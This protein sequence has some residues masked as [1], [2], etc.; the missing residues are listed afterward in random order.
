[1]ED[2]AA[3]PPRTGR[4]LPV[5]LTAHP[6][7]SWVVPLVRQGQR[8]T[9]YQVVASSADGTVWDSGRI[10]SG[11]NAHVRWGGPPVAPHSALRWTVRV[12]DEHARLSP[13]AHA[14]DLIAGPLTADDWTARWIEIPA[15]H[16]AGE[17]FSWDPA[18]RAWRARLH[19]AG[20]GLLR[21]LVDG[22]AVNPDASDPSRTA[23]SRAASRSYDV[24]GLLRDGN[25]H[26]L[27]VVAGIGHYG[28]VLTEPRAL[29][30]LRV[31]LDNGSVVRVGTGPHWRHGPS[32]IIREDPFYLEEHDARRTFT[33]TAGTGVSGEPARA[34]ERPVATLAP[35]AGPPLAVVEEI[36]AIPCGDAGGVLV[37]DAG[38][39]VAGRSRVVVRGAAP[40]TRIEIVHGEKL[41]DAGRVGTLNIRLPDDRDR[42][43]Q[44]LVWTCAGG[45]DVAEAWFAFY[46]FRYVEV[47]GVPAGAAV[48]VTARVLHSDVALTGIFASDEPLLD[49]LVAMAVRTQRN[50]SHSHPEDCPTREQGG[51]TGDASVSAEAA[52]S[53]LDMAGLYRHWLDDVV[54]DQRPDGGVL[55]LTPHLLGARH[56]QPADPVWG[57][58]MTE[59]PLQ[60]W[61]HTGDDTLIIRLLPAMRRWCDWQLGTLSGGVVRGAD[62]S[63]GADWLA[64]E[65]TSPVMLQTAAVIR[66]LRALAE[67]EAVAGDGCEVARREREADALASTARA[68]LHDPLT[69]EWADSGQGSAAVALASGLASDEAERRALADQI[70]VDMRVRGDRVSTGFAATQLLVRAMAEADG[71]TALI[72]AVRQPEQPGIGAMLTTGPGT[73][74]E[75]WWIDDENAGV[76]SLD[77]IGLAAPFAAWAWTYVAGIRPLAEGY[78]RFAVA[79]CLLGPVTRIDVTVETVRGTIALGW[80]LDGDTLT[81]EL[82]VPVGSTALVDLPGRPAQE[83]ESGRHRIVATGIPLAQEWP[84]IGRTPPVPPGQAVTAAVLRGAAVSAD[85]D[86]GWKARLDGHELRIEAPPGAPIG[87]CAEVVLRGAAGEPLARRVVRAGRSARWLS[88]GVRAPG[89]TAGPGVR[90]D[91][92][93]GTFVCT[94]VFHG[95]FPG[96]TFEVNGPPLPPG[97]TRWVLLPLPGGDDLGDATFAFAEVDLCFPVLPGRTI[98]P[99]LRLTGADGS[100]VQDTVRPL[101]VCWNRI[102]V[103]L[104]RW[105]GRERVV[106]VAVGV[107]WLDRPDSARGPAL[108]LDLQEGRS[109]LPFRMGDVGWTSAPRTC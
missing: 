39:N 10:E 25:R 86:A 32:S 29:V 90:L 106:E 107:A 66:S 84:A 17:E 70:R 57:S 49:R 18:C 50:N 27:A 105:P 100:S 64:P 72:A 56:V 2:H 43:R 75:T 30:E 74:W 41:D 35:D 85:A 47:R 98:V 9:A 101:P 83:Y 54:A 94:P 15:T 80:R 73:F 33:G 5:V 1:M 26:T 58:A 21:V 40:G 99:M 65:R 108:P 11:R 28:Q 61:R 37:F 8:Q 81:L 6:R 71:G 46:G 87:S 77:H 44:V 3:E 14:T 16:A 38:C 102:S 79:P 109:S 24:T 92:L 95:T 53:H 4:A 19:L 55:G 48:E 22:Q 67:L 93:H 62:I 91:V 60:H 13:W 103:D 34:V 42:E 51:W 97:Q 63:Y 88:R 68:V 20:Q 59:I 89:W 45:V 12:W 36:A 69:H 78:R 82:T 31:E 52:F 23:L 104:S 7:L 76:A 96:P